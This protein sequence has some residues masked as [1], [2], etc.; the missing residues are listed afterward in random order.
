[1][2]LPKDK[3][4]LHVDSIKFN[5]ALANAELDPK[6]LALKAGVTNNVV[7]TARRGCYVKPM[8][9]GKIAK[10]LSVAVTDLITLQDPIN[11]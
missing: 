4:M 11:E 2:P 5:I 1:M 7:Y 6:T 8:Y 9:L 3:T 10:A